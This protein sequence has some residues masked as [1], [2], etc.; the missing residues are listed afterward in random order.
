MQVIEAINNKIIKMR[1]H[2]QRYILTS[3]NDRIYCKRYY[4]HPFYLQKVVHLFDLSPTIFL[5]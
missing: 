4:Q 1:Q 3:N 2:N 5:P